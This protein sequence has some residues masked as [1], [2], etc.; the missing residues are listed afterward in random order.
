MF[1]DGLVQHVLHCTRCPNTYSVHVH[2]P[3][4]SLPSHV[5]P[6]MPRLLFFRSPAS[7][8][9]TFRPAQ[10][11]HFLPKTAHLLT[12]HRPSL[13]TKVAWLRPFCRSNRAPSATLLFAFQSSSSSSSFSSSSSAT[14]P[15]YTSGL[16]L[17]FPFFPPQTTADALTPPSPP[18]R[19]TVGQCTLFRPLLSFDPLALSL[20]PSLSLSLF[21]SAG[22][23][24]LARFIQLSITKK[25]FTFLLVLHQ[26]CVRNTSLRLILVVSLFFG[27]LVARNGS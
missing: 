20:S 11:L 6:E 25:C 4:R 24:H 15:T 12:F 21:G 10:Q 7:F 3:S 26:K 9:R 1:K 8:L 22:A 16:P 27:L 17:C 2:Q 13:T 14:H 23:L 19:F 18:P 5:R